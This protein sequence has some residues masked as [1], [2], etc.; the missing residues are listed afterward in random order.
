MIDKST[1]RRLNAKKG[2]DSKDIFGRNRLFQV[3]RPEP[4]PIQM[5]QPQFFQIR[6]NK[7]NQFFAI[8]ENKLIEMYQRYEDG[9]EVSSTDNQLEY[10]RTIK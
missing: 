9:E 7:I 3:L 1:R 6:Q 4:S 10:F 5:N 2:R 8:A